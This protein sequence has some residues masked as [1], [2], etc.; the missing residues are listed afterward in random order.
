MHF[1]QTS[2]LSCVGA[3][4]SHANE[5][6]CFDLNKYQVM[7]LTPGSEHSFSVQRLTSGLYFPDQTPK[8]MFQ[9]LRYMLQRGEPY[10]NKLLVLLPLYCYADRQPNP[11]LPSTRRVVAPKWLPL[12]PINQGSLKFSVRGLYQITGAASMAMKKNLN[13]KYK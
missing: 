3:I 9:K 4:R 5:L 1:R 6:E 10:I 11:E 8:T 2:L 12:H 7:R 13:I